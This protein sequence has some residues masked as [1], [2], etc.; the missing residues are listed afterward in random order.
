MSVY[1]TVNR[2]KEVIERIKH[3]NDIIEHRKDIAAQYE[4][5][6]KMNPL[7]SIKG[8]GDAK[9]KSSG[10]NNDVAIAMTMAKDSLQRKK[11]EYDI[12]IA[13]YN[14]GMKK[15]S[16]EERNIIELVCVQNMS[17]E[18]AGEELHLD[19]ST[20][21]RKKKAALQKLEAEMLN[22]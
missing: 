14:R 10:T 4:E 19:R 11:W 22:I 1:I 20:V 15:L 9:G 16:D 7:T 2:T 21:F 18:K 8:S 5:A 6:V 17:E 13:D 3:I 12:M